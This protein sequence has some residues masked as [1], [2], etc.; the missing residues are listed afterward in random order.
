LV[1]PPYQVSIDEQYVDPKSFQIP[2]LRDGTRQE[3]YRKHMEDPISWSIQKLSEHYGTSRD[4]TNAVIFLMGRREELQAKLG[5]VKIPTEHQSMYD[6]HRLDAEAHTP[7]K[8]SE[9]FGI[10]ISQVY[11]VLKNLKIHYARLNTLQKSEEHKGGIM[12]KMEEEG[13]ETSFKE[14]PNEGRLARTYLPRFFRDDAEEETL[15]D[16][17][18]LIAKD[19][20]AKVEP[21]IDDYVN[22]PDRSNLLAPEE[23]NNAQVKTDTFSRW[24]FAYRDSSKLTQQPTMIRTRSGG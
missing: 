1:D 17:K 19:T 12:A 10:D 2:Y 7:E 14:I 13:I 21:A 15:R 16:L 20:R 4:R 9:E 11:D 18:R 23:P 3:M 24:K 6:K 5:A 8:L 22:A